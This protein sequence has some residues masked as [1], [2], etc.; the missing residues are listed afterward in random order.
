ARYPN[1]V[2]AL[3]V[4]EDRHR[5]AVGAN[6]VVQVLH[7]VALRC[8][9]RGELVLDLVRQNRAGAVGQLVASDDR[10]DVGQPLVGGGE[11]VR[12]VAACLAG[13]CRQP[14]GEAATAGFRVDVGTR[15]GD[16]VEADF[17]GDVQ[18]LVDVAHAGEVVDARLRRVVRPVKVDGDGVVPL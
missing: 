6:L 8:A 15:S 1:S 5:D 17:L 11:V 16:D 14:T 9:G 2:A 4:A 10:V 7:V 12:R 3:V 18:Q 13:L